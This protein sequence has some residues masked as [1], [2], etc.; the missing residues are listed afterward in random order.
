LAKGKNGALAP[1]I[2]SARLRIHPARA[3]AKTGDAVNAPCFPP[4][5]SSIHQ[6]RVKVKHYLTSGAFFFLL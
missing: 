4:H 1:S 5:L 3:R 6:V 2:L